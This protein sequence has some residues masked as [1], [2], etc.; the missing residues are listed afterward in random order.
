MQ[1]PTISWSGMPWS[2]LQLSANPSFII[3]QGNDDTMKH[4]LCALV[5]L[6][7]VLLLCN[8]PAH[9]ESPTAIVADYT[10]SPSVLQHG[11]IGTITAVIKN[12]AGS[13]NVRPSTGIQTGRAFEST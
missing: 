2:L 3:Q 5:C 12:T 8:V 1:R 13:A 11:D 10:L 4:P 9:A 6:T 7:A